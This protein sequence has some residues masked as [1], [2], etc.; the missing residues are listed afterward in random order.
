[1]TESPPKAN[2]HKQIGSMIPSF[3]HLLHHIEHTAHHEDE[4]YKP[5]W[6]LKNKDTSEHFFEPA[7]SSASPSCSSAASVRADSIEP[8]AEPKTTD[9]YASR[10]DFW[11]IVLGPS[12]ALEKPK[13]KMQLSEKLTKPHACTGCSMRFKKR[14]NLQSHVRSVHQKLRPFSCSVCL[15]KFGRKSNCAKHVSIAFL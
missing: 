15:R 6:E 10:Q 1:M 9:S 12:H 13:P 8:I 14:C 4:P 2:P 5:L 7:D 11:T 3:Q